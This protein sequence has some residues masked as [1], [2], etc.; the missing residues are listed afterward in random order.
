[1]SVPARAGES[2]G[3]VCGFARRPLHRAVST[4]TA[5]LHTRPSHFRDNSIENGSGSAADSSGGGEGVGATNDYITHVYNSMNDMETVGLTVDHDVSHGTPPLLRGLDVPKLLHSMA[6]IQK[7]NTELQKQLA[8]TVSLLSTAAEVLNSY[9][10]TK[11]L[12]GAAHS[13]GTTAQGLNGA[14][15]EANG[16]VSE[17]QAME[18]GLRSKLQKQKEGSD[19]VI[20]HPGTMC[21]TKTSVA[22]DFDADSCMVTVQTIARLTGLSKGEEVVK[23]GGVE[24]PHLVALA[25][26]ATVNSAAEFSRAT[27]NNLRANL[28]TT[29]RMN[30]HKHIRK[31]LLRGQI[32]K[33]ESRGTSEFGHESF[34][35]ELKD[36]DSEQVIRAMFKPRVQGDAEGWHRAPIEA[37]AYKLN[38]LLG[39]DHVPPVSYRTGGIDVDFHHFE[40][41]AFMYFS[42]HATELKDHDPS[43]WGTSKEVFLSNTRIL[44]VLL[45]NSDRHH[46]HFLMGDHWVEGQWEDGTWKGLQ[47]PMLID[48]AAGFRKEAVVL[49]EHENAF[50]TGPVRCV[51]A[52][53]Y[54]RLRF[55]DAASIANS[56]SHFLSE[57]EMRDMLIR[58]NTILRYLDNLVETQGYSS[59]VIE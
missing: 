27:N 12:N 26:Q 21:S 51:S 42:E 55:L 31:V 1:M 17:E 39:M 46:G 14:N 35:V 38:L 37:V 13:N 8:E 41:G 3:R 11:Q 7:K 47:R 6:D 54:L 10:E 2:S 32:V 28:H 4:R 57:R 53:T 36:P 59:T 40:E 20:Q 52:C 56:F 29:R 24:M 23:P 9:S 25:A 34:E 45:H 50:Q 44:D 15:E 5:A 30:A 43:A 18:D 33:A 22:R 48:H 19:F 49:M 16:K 58:R